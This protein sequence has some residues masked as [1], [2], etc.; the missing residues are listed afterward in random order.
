MID[1][2]LTVGG[3]VALVIGAE[4]MIRGAVDIAFRARIS[5]LVV[6]LTV[7]SMGTSAPELLVSLIAAMKGSSAIAI[8]NV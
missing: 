3:L 8:G 2:L 4:V 6:G 5:P 7:V 1:M